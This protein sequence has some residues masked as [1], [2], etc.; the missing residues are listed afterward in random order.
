MSLVCPCCG[1]QGVWVEARQ[2]CGNCRFVPPPGYVLGEGGLVL[3]GL[4]GAPA[5][6][7]AGGRVPTTGRVGPLVDKVYTAAAE[8]MIRGSN[9]LEVHRKLSELGLDFHT[10][11]GVITSL[12]HYF[13][14][15]LEVTSAAGR[16]GSGP[17]LSG[18]PGWQQFLGTVA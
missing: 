11:L 17:W 4:S 9:R 14:R 16:V 2:E 13:A 1:S 7:A 6:V 18:A 15:P 10:A 12:E 3:A 8:L 5:A